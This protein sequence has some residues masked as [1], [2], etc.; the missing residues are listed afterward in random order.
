MHVGATACTDGQLA[1]RSGNTW[2]VGRRT[3]TSSVPTLCGDEL[4]IRLQQDRGTGRFLPSSSR[5]GIANLKTGEEAGHEPIR[6]W[7]SGEKEDE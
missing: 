2:L 3:V 5:I 1:S 7:N 6:S 4:Q